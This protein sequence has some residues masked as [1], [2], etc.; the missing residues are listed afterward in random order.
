[1][2]PL[3]AKN[4]NSLRDRHI[5]VIFTLVLAM[6]TLAL[7]PL[8]ASLSTPQERYFHVQ[9]SSFNYSPSVLQVD[10]GDWVT[11]EL[12]SQD[13][14]HGLYIDGY[15]LEVHADPDQP[16]RVS[17]KAD[18][19]GSFRIRCSVT[20]GALHPFM[21]GELK[22]GVNWLFWKALAGATLAAFAGLWLV[23]R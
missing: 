4:I 9:A 7:I 5:R 13:V 17:F 2:L 23:R 21:I 12:S 6:L 20:C 22:V 1:M 16:A 11:I 15:D 8:P 10:P 19:R 14:T 3:S 18:Q